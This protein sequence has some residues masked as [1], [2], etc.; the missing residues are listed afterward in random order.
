MHICTWDTLTYTR[1]IALISL[2][3]HLLDPKKCRTRFARC[4][5]PSAFSQTT[6][7]C[8]ALREEGEGIARTSLSQWVP[9]WHLRGAQGYSLM[10]PLLLMSA[11]AQFL[12]LYCSL[13]FLSTCAAFTVPLPFCPLNTMSSAC[14]LCL[15]CLPT[16]S[17]NLEYYRDKKERKY[18]KR[19]MVK[20]KTKQ[21]EMHGGGEW[22][23]SDIHPV[24][25]HHLLKSLRILLQGDVLFWMHSL[26]QLLFFTVCTGNLTS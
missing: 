23:C 1:F 3:R 2:L 24:K 8:P 19:V 13:V 14:L 17:N 4:W 10:L 26:G 20:T 7:D 9:P 12:T 5:P 15:Q 25:M 21:S 6:A 11:F 22:G 16:Q 18:I